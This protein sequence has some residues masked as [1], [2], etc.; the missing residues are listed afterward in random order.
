M[1][2][3]SCAQNNRVG[4][5]SYAYTCMY[6]LDCQW[7]DKG[8]SSMVA[9]LW[10]ACNARTITPFPCMQTT[11]VY[12]Q[13][14]SCATRRI[15]GFTLLQSTRDEKH[16]PLASYSYKRLSFAW[17]LHFI[18]T[19][20]LPPTPPW[21]SHRIVIVWLTFT[22]T[23]P[24][25]LHLHDDLASRSE[26]KLWSREGWERTGKRRKREERERESERERVGEEG[27]RAVLLI[28]ANLR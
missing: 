9:T 26:I 5:A 8:I 24:I 1:Y 14:N 10:T 25:E 3:Q 22:N 13:C 12:K 27:E 17:L 15:R 7:A 6:L 2:V 11:H 18:P 23:S 16:W 4:G 21:W 28:S 19:P 20:T